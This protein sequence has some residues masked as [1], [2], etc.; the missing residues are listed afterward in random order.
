MSF[1]NVAQAIIGGAITTAVCVDN[2]FVE[3]YSDEPGDSA[4]PAALFR[5]FRARECTLDVY[6]FSQRDTW[7]AEGAGVLEGK[8]LLILDWELSDTAA[9]K[10]A[11]ALSILGQAVCGG[12][13]PFV[14]IYTQT[15]SLEQVAYAMHAHFRAPPSERISV[16]LEAAD[17]YLEDE[18]G[19]DPVRFFEATKADFFDLSVHVKDSS[20]ARMRIQAELEQA[21]D[22]GTRSGARLYSELLKA[23]AEPLGCVKTKDTTGQIEIALGHCVRG[24]EVGRHEQDVALT[25]VE[26]VRAQGGVA[27]RYTYIIDKTL[28]RVVAK[29]AVPPAEIPA[30]LSTTIQDAPDRFVR[31][32][33]L[34]MRSIL[35]KGALRVANGFEGIDELAFFYHEKRFQS[36]ENLEDFLKEMWKE[37]VGAFIMVQK[38]TLL[39]ELEA[40]KALHDVESALATRY[41]TAGAATELPLAQLNYYYS[42]LQV[43]R[44]RQDVIRFGDIFSV[45][46][47]DG[48]EARP[49]LQGK[50]LLCITAHCDCVRPAK[51]HDQFMFVIGEK[52]PLAFGLNAGDTGHLSFI[53]GRDGIVC[54]DWS[55]KPFTVHIDPAQNHIGEIRCMVRGSDAILHHAGYQK[56]NYTQRVANQAFSNAMRV[57]VN[58][59]RFPLPSTGEAA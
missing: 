8:D 41:V 6:R 50:Y 24:V 58:F 5:A 19:L 49:D 30:D 23:V 25:C 14:Y 44:T 15:P 31:L 37:Q 39:A 33:S 35:R 9:V 38:P 20:A 55:T 47:P 28:V 48:S 1:E 12:S 26:S 3:P 53:K 18:L 56:E 11:D 17:K 51:I 2:E 45:V 43:P 4:R 59:A 34:E 27:G 52:K 40:Y 16:V 36:P 32:L 22:R 7:N 46:I 10:Y 21:P 54:I 57:G 42:S 29:D 13:I